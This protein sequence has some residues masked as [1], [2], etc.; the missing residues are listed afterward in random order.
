MSNKS[1]G[2][3]VTD[4]FAEQIHLY[5]TDKFKSLDELITEALNERYRQ[6]CRDQKLQQASWN[7][8]TDPWN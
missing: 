3:A 5:G 2:K 8:M 6:G 4:A 7:P 1:S